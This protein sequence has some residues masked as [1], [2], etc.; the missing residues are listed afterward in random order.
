MSSD[1][2]SISA[3]KHK[4]HASHQGPVALALVTVSDTRTADTDENGEYLAEQI[5]KKKHEL[6]C[7]ELVKDEP[8]QIERVL[9]ECV[10]TVAQVILFNGG[11]G[12]SSRDRTFDVLSSKL[13]KTLSGFGEIFRMLSYQEIGAAA[14]LSR[15]TAGVYQNKVI[16]SIPGSPNAVKLAWT[17]LIEPELQHL[18]WEI[19]R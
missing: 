13:E 4:K 6:I 10:Q 18:A 8:D 11:T 12:V 14:M 15:A 9:E 7:Y 19:L 5:L 16:I 3:H 17:K 1:S 2:K